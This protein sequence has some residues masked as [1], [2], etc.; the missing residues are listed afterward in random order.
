MKLSLGAFVTANENKTNGWYAQ[1]VLPFNIFGTF[2]FT[3]DE[4]ENG[5]KTKHAGFCCKEC[6]FRFCGANASC[7]GC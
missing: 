3:S 6:A 2:S 1:D 5:S 7:L 4:V